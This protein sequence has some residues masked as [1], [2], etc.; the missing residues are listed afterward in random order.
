MMRDTVEKLNKHIKDCCEEAEI[1][2]PVTYIDYSG[3]KATEHTSPKH[4]LITNHTARKTFIT[5][6]IMLGM[7]T[8]TIKGITGHKKDSVFN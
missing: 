4:A 5:N 3:G 6:S 2:T 1:N 8:K 7:N